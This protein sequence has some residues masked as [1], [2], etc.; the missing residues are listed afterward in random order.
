[1]CESANDFLMVGMD[2][3][4]CAVLF[5]DADVA[6]MLASRYVLLNGKLLR[7][8]NGEVP[9]LE[10]AFVPAGSGSPLVLD[11]LSYGFVVFPS[12]GATACPGTEDSGNS[13]E[14][15]GLSTAAVVGI[16]VG[17]AAVVAGVGAALYYYSSRSSVAKTA[18]TE[19]LID[20]TD[21]Q[22]IQ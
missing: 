11:P 13:A 5:A 22:L 6:S 4:S 8:S 7:S 2:G 10:A 15:K 3:W 20:P 14:S 19:E 9:A 12:L 16:A 21:R 18:E 17:G 1:M